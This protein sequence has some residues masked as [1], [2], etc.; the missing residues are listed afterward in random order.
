VLEVTWNWYWLWD[1]LEERGYPLQL[2]HPLKTKA[3]ASARIKTDKI[4][5]EIL[6]HFHRLMCGQAMKPQP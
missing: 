3:I 2:A 5:Y 4:D 1:F 6:A